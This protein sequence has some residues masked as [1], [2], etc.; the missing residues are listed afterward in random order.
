MSPPFNRMRNLIKHL[1]KTSGMKHLRLLGR[2]VLGHVRLNIIARIN[3][4]NYS[5]LCTSFVNIRVKSV[6]M[7]HLTMLVHS[8]A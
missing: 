3:F 7:G 1:S 6:V 4:A 2:L 5:V 8:L